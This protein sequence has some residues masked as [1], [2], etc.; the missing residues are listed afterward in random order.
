MVASLFPYIFT[1]WLGVANTAPE[2]EIL[3]Y[4]KWSFYIG[5]VVFLSAVL[6]TREYPHEGMATFQAEKRNISLSDGMKE[7]VTDTF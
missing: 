4:V 6:W 3:P 2:G 5:C 1:N 7:N